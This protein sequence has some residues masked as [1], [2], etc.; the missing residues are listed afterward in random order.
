[1]INNF[2]AIVCIFVSSISLSVYGFGDEWSST[3]SFPEIHSFFLATNT[4]REAAKIHDFKLDW[5][6]AIIKR[7]IRYQAGDLGIL[8]PALERCR[9]HEVPRHCD[10]PNNGAPSTEDTTLKE[11]RDNWQM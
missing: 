1:M 9:K 10:I 5:I 4:D 6:L 2:P 3:P 8:G 11:S 7:L